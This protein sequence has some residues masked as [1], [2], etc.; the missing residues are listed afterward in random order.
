MPVSALT[1]TQVNTACNNFAAISLAS[2]IQ[3]QLIVVAEKI[4]ST[5]FETPVVAANVVEADAAADCM[6]HTFLQ[7]CLWGYIIAYNYVNLTLL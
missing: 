2:G 1:E 7:P 5:I 4:T 3:V 6:D